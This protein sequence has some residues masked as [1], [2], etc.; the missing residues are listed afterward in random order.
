MAESES[1]SKIVNQNLKKLAHKY[2][3]LIP[4]EVTFKQGQGNDGIDKI[5]EMELSAP[6]PRIFAKSTENSF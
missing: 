1:L 6:G 2:Q 4:C 5:C 3:F